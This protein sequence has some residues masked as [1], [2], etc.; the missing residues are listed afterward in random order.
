VLAEPEHV[1]QVQDR[2]P[3]NVI[4]GK[5]ENLFPRLVSGDLD[6]GIAGVNLVRGEAPNVK[7]LFPN[8][9]ELDRAYYQRTGILQPFLIVAVKN[10]AIEAHPGL[11]E[12]VWEAFLEAKRLTP[13]DKLPNLKDVIGDADPLPYGL[14]VNRAGFEE[15]IRLAR[16]YEV[17]TKPMTP[18]EIFPHFN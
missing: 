15:A 7:P 10:A 3:A 11:L 13:V 5:G 6:A 12:A 14:D 8:A 18:D 1:P 16:E 4:P 9:K 17:I 2:L